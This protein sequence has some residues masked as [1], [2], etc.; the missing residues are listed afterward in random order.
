MVHLLQ[1]E[2]SPGEGCH[3]T[4]SDLG[5]SCTSPETATFS[6]MSR[7]PSPPLPSPSRSLP[8]MKTFRPPSDHVGTV[9]DQE[10][11]ASNL[12]DPNT[13]RQNGNNNNNGHRR[14]VPATPTSPCHIVTPR[15]A[16][17]LPNDSGYHSNTCGDHNCNYGNSSTLNVLPGGEQLRVPGYPIPPHSLPRKLTASRA[18]KL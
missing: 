18:T 3:T 4:T 15:H 2:D 14:P 17:L 7:S 8:R 11:G 6:N 13:Q 1:G 16:R 5:S 10:G 12:A 9:C